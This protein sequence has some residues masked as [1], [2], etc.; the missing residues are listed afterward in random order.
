MCPRRFI[1]SGVDPHA[2]GLWLFGFHCLSF[3]FFYV[4]A[5]LTLRCHNLRQADPLPSIPH[6]R[7]QEDEVDAF[8]CSVVS[9]AWTV[10]QS[11]PVLEPGRLGLQ[12]NA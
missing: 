8:G 5:E 2:T 11:L 4:T 3:V 9:K 10:P 1:S 12:A 6:E 7:W